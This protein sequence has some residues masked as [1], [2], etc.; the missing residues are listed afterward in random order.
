MP[1]PPKTVHAPPQAPRELGIEAWGWY[2][3]MLPPI[4]TS[5]WYWMSCESAAKVRE[6]W[7][8]MRIRGR[9]SLQHGGS[10]TR[11]GTRS[12]RL[13]RSRLIHSSLSLQRGQ[14]HAL[15]PCRGRVG[16]R[17]GRTV[18]ESARHGANDTRTW[19]RVPQQARRVRSTEVTSRCGH[20]QSR[21]DAVRLRPAA[22]IPTLAGAGDSGARVAPVPGHA[23]A[24]EVP[25]CAP[26]SRHR[27]GP[28]VDHG[29]VP[30]AGIKP[31]VAVPHLNHDP[32]TLPN[33]DEG[34]VAAHFEVGGVGQR[35]ATTREEGG[36]REG[37]G[38]GERAE[39]TVDRVAWVV[40]PT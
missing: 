3:P 19:T 8:R 37:G 1:A 2:P 38:E 29:E 18:I 12:Q 13:P 20:R 40:G 22:I 33:Q 6:S 25:P 28:E 24:Q 14:M 15:G 34:A 11:R 26:A 32:P 5:R 17:G 27:D 30:A 35:L 4:V 7:P 21:A 9:Q 16:T 31:R 10:S 39:E 36:G 23:A